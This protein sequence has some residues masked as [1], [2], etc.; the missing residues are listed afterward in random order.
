MIAIVY[1]AVQGRALQ[2]EWFRVLLD[3]RFGICEQILLTS[4]VVEY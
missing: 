2:G 4:T 3:M 1:P